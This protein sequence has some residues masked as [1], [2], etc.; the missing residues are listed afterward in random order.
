M[1]WERLRVFAA[2]VEHESITAA[3]EALHL[4][5]PAVSQQIRKLEKETHCR[6]V[7]PDGR[8]VRLTTA[9]HILAKTTQSMTTLVADTDR[10]LANIHDQIV[11]PLR[12]GA[13][14]SVLRAL[15]PEVLQSLTTQHPRLEPT[16]RD[17]ETI[18]LLPA[19][20]TRRLDVAVIESWSR[21]PTTLPPGVQAT[22][23]LTEDVQ[24]AV[25]DQHPLAN[26][27]MVRLEELRGQ[28]WAVCPAGSDPYEAL[29]QILRDY[30]IDVDIRYWVVDYITQLK[31][32]AAG[33]AVALV[34]QF[35]RTEYPDGVRFIPC[36][37]TVTRTITVATANDT[38]PAARAFVAELLRAA[39][40]WSNHDAF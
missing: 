4:T 20:R 32:A 31:L 18:D 6:L 30:N 40:N 27:T 25:H 37:P 24:V 15:I 3:A 14:A 17:G 11:G 26:Q 36:E 13:V 33:L 5:R 21:H 23:V 1:S 19:L 12:I 9:G 34:P 29:V 8:G 2:V 38:I 28:Q 35:A 16:L 39:K 7:E 10:D 22:N